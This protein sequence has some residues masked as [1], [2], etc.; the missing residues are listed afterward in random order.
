MLK[1]GKTT[2]PQISVT[3]CISFSEELHLLLRPEGGHPDWTCD[4]SC[5]LTTQWCQHIQHIWLAN[6]TALNI[7]V[8]LVLDCRGFG[9][10]DGKLHLTLITTYQST[11]RHT[12][13]DFS[14]HKQCCRNLQPHSCNM[15]LPNTRTPLLSCRGHSS[16]T[17]RSAHK[18]RP[19]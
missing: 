18:I 1:Y 9:N 15:V 14:P 8:L 13:H 3:T 17:E 2:Y 11:R 19:L 7:P 5:V 12:L 16:P 4:I 10:E 6:P